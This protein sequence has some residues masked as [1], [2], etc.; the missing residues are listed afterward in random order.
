M[1][2]REMYE[3]NFIHLHHTLGI[4]RETLV[5]MLKSMKEDDLM[6][7]NKE[8]NLVLE[9]KIITDEVSVI[10][11]PHTGQK[12]RLNILFIGL[13]IFIP[14]YYWQYRTL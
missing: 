1:K 12:K 11:S 3:S 9:R 6:N 14:R 5:K 8:Y 7:I 13:I 2:I 10:R 4:K